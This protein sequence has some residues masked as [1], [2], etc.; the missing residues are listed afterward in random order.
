MKAQPNLE[1]ATDPRHDPELDTDGGFFC[2]LKLHEQILDLP[3]REK[4]K[5]LSF[6]N[7]PKAGDEV[8]GTATIYLHSLNGTLQ[9]S[10]LAEY[11][12]LVLLKLCD[13]ECH[14]IHYDLRGAHR[15]RINSGHHDGRTQH[16]LG[17]S[18]EQV[19]KKACLG[20][21]PEFWKPI[22]GGIV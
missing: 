4:L 16:F 15:I 7:G 17:A 9:A 10:S 5:T 8:Y 3:K 14:T 18:F 19:V 6:P 12:W 2:H 20:M 1:Y 21:L 22:E 11:L 13:V